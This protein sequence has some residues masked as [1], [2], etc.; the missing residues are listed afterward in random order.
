[1]FY[2]IYD[3]GRHVALLY[4]DGEAT[5]AAT[6]QRGA[7]SITSRHA[8]SHYCCISRRYDAHIAAAGISARRAEVGD[9][10]SRPLR[11]HDML[12]SRRN[13]HARQE[14]RIYC[15]SQRRLASPY[16]GRLQRY[17]A[18]TELP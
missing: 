5:F 11:R 1:M 10:T 14:P 18:L 9:F 15:H 2:D 12:I 17:R 13:A 3:D 16:Y 8:A 4:G 6:C 7:A